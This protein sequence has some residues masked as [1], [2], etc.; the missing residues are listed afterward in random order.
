M[1]NGDDSEP[2]KKDFLL[3]GVWR[4]EASSPPLRVRPRWNGM[5]ELG[6]PYDGTHAL[7]VLP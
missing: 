2:L 5:D 4:T 3:I 1:K 6:S 7:K